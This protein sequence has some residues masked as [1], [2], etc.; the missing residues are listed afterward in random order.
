MS[1]MT[2]EM[3]PTILIEKNDIGIPVFD[4]S[5]MFTRFHTPEMI[6]LPV[7]VGEKGFLLSAVSFGDPMLVLF[8]PDFNRMDCEKIGNKISN[9]ALLHHAHVVFVQIYNR[10][11][12]TIGFYDANEG[13][14]TPPP[15]AYGAALTTGAVTHRLN[16]SAEFIRDGR[17]ILAEWDEHSNHVYIS[18]MN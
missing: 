14:I 11:S 13:C 18:L 15:E 12:A 2:T 16:R 7:Q 6:D 8:V 4:C 1:A 3:L 17:R 9:H 5:E 10:K